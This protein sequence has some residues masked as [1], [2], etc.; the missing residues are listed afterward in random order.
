MHIDTLDYA[1]TLEKAGIDRRHA[2]AIA[3][4]QA[5]AIDDLVK[6]ELVTKADMTSALTDLETRLRGE[7]HKLGTDLRGETAQ[8]GTDL[9]G[10]TA[11]LGTDLRGEMAKLGTDLRGEMA[12][13]GTDL[14]G[15]IQQAVVTMQAEF[16]ALKYAASIAAFALALIVALARLIR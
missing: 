1:T 11:Q 2:E 5:K 9:R 13:L 4:L 16:R 15:E 7:I 12:K 3:K 6:N 8:L 14:R 10:E